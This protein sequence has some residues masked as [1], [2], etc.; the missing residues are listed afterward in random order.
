MRKRGVTSFIAQK[1]E[2]FRA[3]HHQ[4]A[5][6]AEVGGQSQPTR[7]KRQYIAAQVPPISASAAG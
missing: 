3:R 4:T 1:A 5:L 7:R 6:A 2:I